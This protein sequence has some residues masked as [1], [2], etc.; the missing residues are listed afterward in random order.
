MI[1]QPTLHDKIKNI[2]VDALDSPIPEPWETAE[3]AT[4]KIMIML[5][6][7]R[8]GERAALSAFINILMARDYMHPW[9]REELERLADSAVNINNYPPGT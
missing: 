2:I 3:H 4:N 1:R 8:A 6:D 5:P 9:L 7:P